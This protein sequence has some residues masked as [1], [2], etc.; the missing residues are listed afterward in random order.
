MLYV[1]LLIRTFSGYCQSVQILILQPGVQSFHQLVL[2]FK[3]NCLLAP[4]PQIQPGGRA[5][6]HNYSKILIDVNLFLCFGSSP[7][8]ISNKFMSFNFFKSCLKSHLQ[9]VSLNN[10]PP[11]SILFILQNYSSM[12]LFL[13]SASRIIACCC[14]KRPWGFSISYTI[15][16]LNLDMRKLRS[17]KRMRR[18]VTH[19]WRG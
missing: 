9:K 11:L 14:G 17:R 18:K 6:L 5:F 15:P 12:L 2:P 7:T 10:F 13:F 3:P 1:I 8:V 4:T 16:L 19:L